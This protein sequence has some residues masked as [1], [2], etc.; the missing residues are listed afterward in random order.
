MIVM[1]FDARDQGDHGGVC[2]VNGGGSSEKHAF[3]HS[4]RGRSTLVTLP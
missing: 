2:G 3:H 1:C 4:R